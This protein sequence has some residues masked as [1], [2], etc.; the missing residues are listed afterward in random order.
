MSRR[1]ERNQ[2]ALPYARPP[3]RA[4]QDKKSPL[5]S[6]LNGIISWFKATSELDEDEPMEEQETGPSN[7]AAQALVDRGLA[8][9]TGQNAVL[10][11]PPRR[12]DATQPPPLAPQSS[13]PQLPGGPPPVQTQPAASTFTFSHPSDLPTASSTSPVPEVQP[14]SNI[15]T[16]KNFL[17]RKLRPGHELTLDAV[18][19]A[20]VMALLEEEGP[21]NHEEEEKREPFRFS[22]SPSTRGNSPS[23]G[24]FAST[25]AANG[26]PKKP[27]M[28]AKNPNGVYRWQGAGSARPRNRYQ[29]PGFGASRS[30]P[31]IKIAP[32]K[33]PAT[34]GKR[35]RVGEE[36]QTNTSQ[37]TSAPASGAN[38]VSSTSVHNSNG[39][40]SSETF[41]TAPPPQPVASSSKNTLT[42][43]VAPRLRTTGITKPTAPAVP[44][45]LRNSWSND[46]S[47]TPTAPRPT[48]AAALVTDILR[49]VTPSEKKKA[50][51]NPYEALYPGNLK[52][53]PK[54]KKTLK[55]KSSSK[56]ETAPAAAT[57]ES[58]PEEKKR[59]EVELSP[60]KIIEATVPKGAKRARPPPEFEK[61]KPLASTQQPRKAEPLKYGE[62]QT[63]SNGQ[64][65]PVQNKAP[66]KPTIEE[67]PDEE[68]PS[69]PKKAKTKATSSPASLVP[70][71][72]TP[73][74]SAP[75]SVPVPA[76]VKPPVPTRSISIEEVEDQD[77][78]SEPVVKPAQVI[79]PEE[80]KRRSSSPTSPAPSAPGLLGSKSAFGVKSSAPKAPSKLRFS[81]QPE[82]DEQMQD[83]S[84]PTLKPSAKPPS[85]VAAAPAPLSVPQPTTKAPAN[86]AEVKASVRSLHKSELKAYS[87][88][89]PTSSP[90]AGPSTIKARD[91][92]KSTP[93]SELPKYSFDFTAAPAAVSTTTSSFNWG[94]AGAK[95]P[96]ESGDQWTCD[97]CMLK[98]PATATEKCTICDAPRPGGAPK[99]APKAF[100]W[101]AAGMKA[102]P[103]AATG[104]WTCAQCMLQNPE[105]AKEKCTICD[106]PR[107]G[108][109]AAAPAAKG[110]DWAAAGV[111]AQSASPA[112]NW[113]CGTCMLQNPD[114]A[115]E[116]CTICDAPRPDA[117]P[118]AP[119]TKGFDWAA[120]GM[121]PAATS[122]WTCK[123]CM[124]QNPAD[125]TKCTICDEPR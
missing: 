34:D 115:K 75:A 79:E 116:K 107:P 38:G 8:M 7:P 81:I 106:A 29:S 45:P 44:S 17:N 88:D 121:K 84:E 87:F 48:R 39:R 63:I 125:A 82:K 66:P 67:V 119:A 101:S 56:E 70:T 30:Q 35:R 112:G 97:T 105:T 68:Q 74:A 124:L 104:S 117:K 28:L 58:K 89:I 41:P 72:A 31:S 15:E 26:E 123:S 95:K 69:P 32:E 1:S 52:Q 46:P 18:E 20:G 71:F 9:I 49:E 10:P 80:N 40:L 59:K 11:P 51:I 92:A 53:L 16:V 91:A 55:R 76:P 14:R 13:Y 78:E 113:T 47:S 4:S 100:D 43:P 25:S 19:I 24:A 60:A 120:A 83:D 33:V 21:Q 114:S 57:A 85:P 64:S 37:H 110:F 93:V 94:A 36:E 65:F 27:R 73:S 109:K 5:S 90:G 98:N 50:L 3:P 103:A 2:L 61:Q 102:Q 99:A 86:V 23:S 12:N 42:P 118:A 122:G 77:M 22:T 96:S 62:R 111:K 54:K 6:I 108:A